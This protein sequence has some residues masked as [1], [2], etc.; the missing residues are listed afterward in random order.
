MR[1]IIVFLAVVAVGIVAWL[2][3][4]RSS[5]REGPKQKPLKVS[6]HSV[7]FNESVQSVMNSY[8]SLTEGFVNWDT[9]AVDNQAKALK[10]KLDGLNLNELKKDTTGILETAQ[11]FVDNAKNDIQTIAQ[12]TGFANKR[13]GLNS[14]T[15]N[16]FQ[17]LRVV[18]YDETKLYLQ[19]CPMAFGDDDPGIWLSKTDS[20]RNPYLGLHHPKYGKAMIDCGETKDTL[21]FIPKK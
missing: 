5:E 3:F 21:N 9:T 13:H 4:T 18:K 12:D 2:L 1:K 20:I 6:K 14:L 19:Q 15:D 7:A 10:G 16:L 17:F 11:S 8:Y